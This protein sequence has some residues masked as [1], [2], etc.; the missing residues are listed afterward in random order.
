MDH[1]IIKT[2]SV[3]T[4][5]DDLAKVMRKVEQEDFTYLIRRHGS[6]VVAMVPMSAAVA[7]WEAGI[8]EGRSG[9]EKEVSPALPEE[10]VEEVVEFAEGGPLKGYLNRLKS[11]RAARKTKRAALAKAESAQDK[12][13]FKNMR[14]MDDEA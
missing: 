8:L 9:A 11:R 2:I 4:L 14:G 7:L 5:R 1:Q 12:Y 13:R 3:S 6:A 10:V